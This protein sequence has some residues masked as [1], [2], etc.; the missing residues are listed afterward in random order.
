MLMLV[1]TSGVLILGLGVRRNF[2]YLQTWYK[3]MSLNLT[4][5]LSIITQDKDQY[6]LSLF[7]Q[8][9]PITT[10]QIYNHAISMCTNILLNF[11]HVILAFNISIGDN[12]ATVFYTLVSICTMI[13]Y[14]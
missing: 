8:L 3:I 6:K 4:L 5:T 13:K 12:I 7:A 2:L 11:V 1:L 14:C 9:S 10:L